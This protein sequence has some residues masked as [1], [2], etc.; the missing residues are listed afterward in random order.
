MPCE[1]CF[2]AGERKRE[3]EGEFESH[4]DMK[5]AL[6]KLCKSVN[7]KLP[8]GLGWGSFWGII[9]FSVVIISFPLDVQL[10]VA[11][12]WSELDLLVRIE[13]PTSFLD[14]VTIA[15]RKDE[16]YHLSGLLV[17][18]PFFRCTCSFLSLSLS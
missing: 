12:V 9:Q 8:S 1:Y 14:I 4:I 3:R 18:S 10:M 17:F 15:V 6:G 13:L 2:K 5:S 7:Y 11:W 16:N